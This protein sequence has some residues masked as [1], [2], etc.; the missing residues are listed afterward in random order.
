MIVKRKITY[1]FSHF[2]IVLQKQLIST[3][4]LNRNPDVLLRKGVGEVRKTLSKTGNMPFY[5]TL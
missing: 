3:E 5:A 2:L 1:S 4:F